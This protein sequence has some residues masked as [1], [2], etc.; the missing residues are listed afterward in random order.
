MEPRCSSCGRQR[1]IHPCSGEA[2]RQISIQCRPAAGHGGG[3]SSV[4]VQR[5]N[6]MEHADG[7]EITHSRGYLFICA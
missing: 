5:D 3:I 6:D 4:F 1:R 7:I 2:N